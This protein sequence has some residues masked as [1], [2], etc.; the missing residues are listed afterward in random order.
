MP[1]FGQKRSSSNNERK[2][3]GVLQNSIPTDHNVYDSPPLLP[4]PPVLDTKNAMAMKP[5]PPAVMPSRK[6]LL[7]HSQLAH[8]SSIKV[9]NDFS[10]V[11]ELYQKI[12]EVFGLGPN[13][14]RIIMH[15]GSRYD[16]MCEWNI[17]TS[18]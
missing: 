1:L 5:H 4:L 12:S 6:D 3:Y 15:I 16:V 18:L 7:F 13:E 8:G 9:V 2:K 10:N 17:V 14:V 11:K